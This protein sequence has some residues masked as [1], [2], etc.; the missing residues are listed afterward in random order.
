MPT[1]SHCTWYLQTTWHPRRSRQ[2]FLHFKFF[3][4]SSNRFLS[5]G[6]KMGF[7]PLYH[8]FSFPFLYLYILSW[9]LSFSL[10]F[11][12]FISFY[13]LFIFLPFFPFWLFLCIHTDNMGGD[14]I[15][16]IPGSKD[17]LKWISNTFH[18]SEWIIFPENKN[19]EAGVPAVAQWVK[20]LV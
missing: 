15:C 16:K 19:R 10:S 12:F 3:W 18:D 17:F 2:M 7:F 9:L 1:K 20:N 6:L 4:W 14:N 13:V 8:F 11:S 5:R